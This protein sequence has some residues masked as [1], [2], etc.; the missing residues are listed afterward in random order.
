M[1][2]GWGWGWGWEWE[3]YVWL[4]EIEPSKTARKQ[5]WDLAAAVFQRNQDT[6]SFIL[7]LRTPSELILGDLMSSKDSCPWNECWIVIFILEM[8]C[9]PFAALFS[10]PVVSLR[11]RRVLSGVRVRKRKNFTTQMKRLRWLSEEPQNPLLKQ[12]I[13]CASSSGRFSQETEET[14]RK[15]GWSRHGRYSAWRLIFFSGTEQIR[16]EISWETLSLSWGNS[17]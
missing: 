12:I 9:C 16:E 13:S 3:K 5:R 14:Y 11:T 10:F 7:F 2:C 15:T 8:S 1:G 4:D 17:C 6:R